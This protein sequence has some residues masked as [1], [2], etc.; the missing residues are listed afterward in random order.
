LTNRILS[1][2]L[3]TVTLAGSAMAQQ[4][5]SVKPPATAGETAAIARGW[6][7]LADGRAAE[8]SRLAADLLKQ[9][10]R[11]VA[12]ATLFVDAEIARAGSAAG[13]TAY[14]RWLER[15]TLED[16]YVLRRVSR[17]VLRE[18][19]RDANSAVRADAA[20]ALK[21]DGERVETPAT[22][23]T[24]S[25]DALLAQM[26]QP[27]PARVH[28]INALAR[29]RDPRAGPALVAALDDDDMIVRAAAAEAVGT[30][31]AKESVPRLHALLGDP[32]VSVQLAAA[33]ALLALKDSRGADWLRQ[34]AGSEHAMMRLAAVQALKNEAGP[35]W[36]A[37]VRAL[38]GDVNPAV[39]QSAAE[40]IAPYDPGLAEATLKPLLED[41]NPAIRQVARTSF[42]GA[43]ATDLT[44]LRGYLRHEDAFARLRAAARILQ[45]TR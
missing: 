6:T 43:V 42:V 7:L 16:G 12:V 44:T 10:P 9:F 27:G 3:I 41:A 2:G 45:L 17:P 14:E 24:A 35:E 31:G 40:L 4:T 5:G 19:L 30:L 34:L 33:K 1:V 36:Q 22:A 15:R 25:V 20:T 26:A 37:T 13:L 18:L 11:S 28:T 38:T 23:A 29:S 39:R 32:V 8:A 21:E